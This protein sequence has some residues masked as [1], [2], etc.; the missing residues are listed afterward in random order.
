MEKEKNW[1]SDFD[2]M[3]HKRSQKGLVIEIAIF[4]ILLLLL[5]HECLTIGQLNASLSNYKT[6]VSN[7]EQL[8][9]Y[10][11]GILQTNLSNLELRQSELEIQYIS[12][13]SE[14]NN[15]RTELLTLSNMTSNDFITLNQTINQLEILIQIVNET[16]R[17]G[18]AGPQGIQGIQ[19]TQGE[20]GNTGAT[21]AQ[22]IQ[23]PKGDTGAQGPTGA[24]GPQGPVGPQGPTGPKGDKGDKGAK[25][26][27]GDDCDCH[28]WHNC[29]CQYHDC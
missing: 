18:P 6:D 7:V 3:G 24:T 13:V 25:G 11:I 28:C 22:G 27:K 4:A 23:G 2:K 16:S 26:D 10:K 14:L 17:I 5:W 12:L 19:G 20:K 8:L 29:H 1:Y 9:L 15:C 21:G